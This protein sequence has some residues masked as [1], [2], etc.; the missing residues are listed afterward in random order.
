MRSVV[1]IL[2]ILSYYGGIDIQAQRCTMFVI[3]I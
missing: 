2:D 3:T 1:D